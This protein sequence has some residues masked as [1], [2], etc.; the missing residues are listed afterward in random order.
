M[1]GTPKTN[2][3]I[4]VWSNEDGIVNKAQ[5]PQYS[6]M[7][8]V[9][10]SYLIGAPLRTATSWTLHL[11]PGVHIRYTKDTLES[12]YDSA[13]FIL[14][15]PGGEKMVVVVTSEDPTSSIESIPRGGSN[16][17]I[18]FQNP[19]TELIF[20][21]VSIYDSPTNTGE[22]TYWPSGVLFSFLQF[23]KSSLKFK[24]CTVKTDNLL[25]I[26]NEYSTD[27][28]TQVRMGNPFTN[29]VADNCS[30]DIVD[31]NFS[32]E[33]FSAV[34]GAKVSHISFNGNGDQEGRRYYGEARVHNSNFINSQPAETTH[35]G[36]MSFAY[37]N[38]GSLA[39]WLDDCVTFR[40]RG[41]G[42]DD[43]VIPVT[44]L[45]VPLIN[46]GS[47]GY[48]CGVWYVSRNVHNYDT[49]NPGSPYYGSWAEFSGPASSGG[50][51]GY[52]GY[53]MY[54]FYSLLQPFDYL[55]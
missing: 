48:S 7:P 36:Y 39:L 34:E 11:K 17:Y 14:D 28:M 54:E 44:W 45:G 18:S 25:Q 19:N 29:V 33:N 46:N 22:D 8:A 20:N 15:N 42:S 21:N 38:E 23:N 53:G 10:W 16:Q 43:K 41:S 24:N 3:V 9:Y 5:A 49:G 32:I 12:I 55:G 35:A 40:G 37:I 1:S 50:S 47:G 52:A 13:L 51:L 2:G 26:E 4:E 27:S 31:S 6:T 30:L